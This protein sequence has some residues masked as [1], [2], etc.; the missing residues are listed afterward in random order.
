VPHDQRDGPLRPYSLF[1]RQ[2]YS[3]QKHLRYNSLTRCLRAILVSPPLGVLTLLSYHSELDAVPGAEVACSK[4]S[5][6]VSFPVSAV[7]TSLPS[8]NLHI[9]PAVSRRPLPESC[10]QHFKAGF[11]KFPPPTSPISRLLFHKIKMQATPS[12]S[13]SYFLPLSLLSSRLYHSY[14]IWRLCWWGQKDFHYNPL[15][16]R[17][18]LRLPPS[19]LLHIIPTI[20]TRD[21]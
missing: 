21:E 9:R 13:L 8:S 6:E 19:L 7:G 12:P 15:R 14:E 4:V 11:N 10:Y 5:V 17:L 3:G 20:K 18:R 2:F 1:S 16:L